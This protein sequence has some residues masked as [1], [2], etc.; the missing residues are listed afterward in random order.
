MSFNI[1]LPS[2]SQ[3]RQIDKNF[4]NPTVTFSV[5]KVYNKGMYLYDKY[6]VQAE[7]Q[8]FIESN[9]EDTFGDNGA[10]IRVLNAYNNILRDGQCMVSNISIGGNKGYGIIPYI[11]NC[12]CYD[13]GQGPLGLTDLKSEINAS[14]SITENSLQVTRTIEAKGFAN[15]FDNIEQVMSIAKSAVNK[16]ADKGF[17]STYLGVGISSNGLQLISKKSIEDP[18]NASYSI[19]EQYIGIKDGNSFK[20][21]VVKVSVSKQTNLETN[22]T[23]NVSAQ[24]IY[25]E[26]INGSAQ[27]TIKSLREAKQLME[28]YYR[29]DAGFKAV[30]FSWKD[31]PFNATI[32]LQVVYS[33]DGRLSDDGGLQEQ[34]LSFSVDFTSATSELS[35][36][37][38]LRPLYANLMQADPKDETESVINEIKLDTKNFKL[39]SKSEV[40]KERKDYLTREKVL[41]KKW[42]KAQNMIG[43]DFGKG[44]DAY[45]LNLNVSI[46]LGTIQTSYTPILEGK[47]GYYVEDLDFCTRNKVNSKISASV[48]KGKSPPISALTD[49]LKTVVR[50]LGEEDKIVLKDYADTEV[51]YG[52]KNKDI[53]QI[54]IEYEI[55]T[56]PDQEISKIRPTS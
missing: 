55:S 51:Y 36:T 18:A 41:T 10:Y 48:P 31:D 9:S 6:N 22:S 27:N 1:Q 29:A 26:V 25:R 37:S 4:P 47:G 15:T 44:P 23:I 56:K 35:Y 21:P 11:V 19:V 24:I 20:K 32:D 39:F 17:T 30:D 54:N 8:I 33:N 12:E 2:F 14:Y 50:D 43:G 3:A 49:K 45:N 7:G 13:F 38:S 52:A 42:N 46:D 16:I 28:Q 53:G 34:S 40:N 5:E